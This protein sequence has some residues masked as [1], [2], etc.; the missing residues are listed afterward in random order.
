MQEA[1]GCKESRGEVGISLPRKRKESVDSDPI[2]S[3][4]EALSN[5]Q[6]LI[7]P[8]LNSMDLRGVI[9]KAEWVVHDG[10]KFNALVDDVKVFIDVLQ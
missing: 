10:K 4:S 5:F 6:M 8:A 1:Y 9:K 3:L 2:Q 7:E